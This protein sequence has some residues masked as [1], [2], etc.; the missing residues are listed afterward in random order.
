MSKKNNK[1]KKKNSSNYS[2]FGQLAA[3]KKYELIL[4]KFNLLGV[5]TENSFCGVKLVSSGPN[6]IKLFLS[7][8][9]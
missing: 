5:K 6:V 4:S 8:N 9:Y 3:D 2:V 7:V 1:N